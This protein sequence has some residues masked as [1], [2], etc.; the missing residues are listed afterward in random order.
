[1]LS[2]DGKFSRPGNRP[3]SAHKPQYRYKLIVI[4]R[5]LIGLR[6]EIHLDQPAVNYA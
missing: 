2:I 6:T 3:A 4:A 5:V 1:M